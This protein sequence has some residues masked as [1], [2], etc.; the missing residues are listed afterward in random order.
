[1]RLIRWT[2]MEGSRV[3]SYCIAAKS[4]ITL[5]R[6][7]MSFMKYLKT[8]LDEQQQWFRLGAKEE[9]DVG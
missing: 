3:D 7:V 9:T 5:E 4:N 1:M 8:K 6:D 2:K